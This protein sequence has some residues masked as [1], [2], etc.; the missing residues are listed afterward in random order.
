MVIII[1]IYVAPGRL[2]QTVRSLTWTLPENTI[3]ASNMF[4]KSP[5][6]TAPAE[7]QNGLSPFIELFLSQLW[8]GTATLA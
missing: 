1:S 8:P 3:I 7:H 2:N 6:A 4:P 5:A